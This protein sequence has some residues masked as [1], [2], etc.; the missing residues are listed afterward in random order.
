M[1][2]DNV[3][4]VYANW[5]KLHGYIY[6]SRVEGN[7]QHNFYIGDGP[8][9]GQYFEDVR[10]LLLYVMG[11]GPDLLET[12][13]KTMTSK[14]D[15]IVRKLDIEKEY[16]LELLCRQYKIHLMPKPQFLCDLVMFLLN[17]L[18]KNILIKVKTNYNKISDLYNIK[19]KQYMPAIV[20][21]IS[22]Q[23]QTRIILDYLKNRLGDME[24]I[25]VAPAYNEKVSSLIYYAGGDR[26]V[27]N[28]AKKYN[29]DIFTYD[30]K[31]YKN[32]QL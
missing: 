13:N 2:C 23:R 11:D 10:D 29:I 27:K 5:Y 16:A 20:L 6:I 3:L 28:L 18:P 8:L 14:F 12:W 4:Q 26:D 1:E 19:Q 15:R 22:G 24:G 17:N 30:Y 9:K 7:A 32:C 31:F 21:Y 25:D